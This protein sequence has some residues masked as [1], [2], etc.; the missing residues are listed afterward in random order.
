MITYISKSYTGMEIFLKTHLFSIFFFSGC[1][2]VYPGLLF[3]SLPLL[4][5]GPLITGAGGRVVQWSTSWGL[6]AHWQTLPH[7]YMNT[8]LHCLVLTLSIYLWSN[9]LAYGDSGRFKGIQAWNPINEEKRVLPAF[10]F[11]AGESINSSVWSPSRRNDSN[12]TCVLLWLDS[13]TT[14]AIHPP[15]RR[16]S[17]AVLVDIQQEFRR[18][19][20]GG[21]AG[22]QQQL[23]VLGQVLSRVLL[24]QPG[25]VQQLPL[26]KWQ[27]GLQRGTALHY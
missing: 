16:P 1:V 19:H 5:S 25:T 2:C 7:I 15:V 12:S 24:G 4:S 17:L 14:D 10:L 11:G 20:G 23:L 6:V 27:V 22:V 8:S 9:I 26:E 18:V 13:D 21:G 3:L